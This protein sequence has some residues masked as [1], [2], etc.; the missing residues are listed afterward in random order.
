MF[1]KDLG[2]GT[3]V[4][5]IFWNSQRKNCGFHFYYAIDKSW[6]IIRNILNYYWLI[7]IPKFP[8]FGYALLVTLLLCSIFPSH[9]IRWHRRHIRFRHIKND[10]T[11]LGLIPTR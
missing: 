8:Y 11:R 4:V 5:S 10:R 7:R 3:L 9:A 1:G 6:E 2:L